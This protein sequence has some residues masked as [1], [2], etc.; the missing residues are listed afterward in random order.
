MTGLFLF[1]LLWN[2]MVNAILKRWI[3]E[4]RPSG[5]A[6]SSDWTFLNICVG[7]P[8]RTDYGMPSSHAQFMG[9]F[10]VYALLHLFLK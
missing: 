1:G 7:T 6:F 3:K 10:C 9:F 2:E 5:P 4:S 8:H